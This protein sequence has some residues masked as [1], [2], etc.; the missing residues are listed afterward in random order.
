[1]AFDI[2][3]RPGGTIIDKLE[4][5]SINVEKSHLAYL[6]TDESEKKIELRRKLEGIYFKKHLNSNLL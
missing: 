3:D 1:M 4:E 6:Q 5:I 2:L